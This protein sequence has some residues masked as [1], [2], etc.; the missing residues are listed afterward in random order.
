MTLLG[1]EE[2]LHTLPLLALLLPLLGGRYLGEERLVALVRSRVARRPVRP[3]LAHRPARVALGLPRG[4]R[5]IATS[6]AV[7][8]P[9]VALA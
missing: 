6:L 3:G 2:L 9:P 8:P 1:A 5:L 4:G 7:R